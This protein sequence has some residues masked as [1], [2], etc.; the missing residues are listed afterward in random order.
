M[1]TRILWLS[2]LHQKLK[3]LI[4]ENLRKAFL[5]LFKFF[6]SYSG[7]LQNFV[8]FFVGEWVFI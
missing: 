8:R 2:F 5:V 6:D 7:D 3:K 1:H 4:C